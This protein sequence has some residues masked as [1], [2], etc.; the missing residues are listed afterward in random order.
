[1]V[2][3]SAGISWFGSLICCLEL[4]DSESYAVFRGWFRGQFVGG[5][6]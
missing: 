1:M 3:L 6:S 5:K 4:I 2:D